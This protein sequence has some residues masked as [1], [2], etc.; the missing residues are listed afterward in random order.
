MTEF[1]GF[2]QVQRCAIGAKKTYY[3][4]ISQYCLPF[5]GS[6][7]KESMVNHCKLENI[8]QEIGCNC[9]HKRN[10]C[11]VVEGNM[12]ST[13]VVRKVDKLGRIVLPKELREVLNVAIQ[14]P[15][16]IYIDSNSILLKKYQPGCIICGSM[17]DTI[18]FKE[19]LIC[20]KCI[21]IIKN[22]NE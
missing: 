19:K 15:L 8:G 5:Q 16:E 17:D 7:G 10:E 4:I 1:Q 11:L 6:K 22:Y 3:T 14:D 21:N 12:K 2:K 9:I 13:G 18:R 20:T